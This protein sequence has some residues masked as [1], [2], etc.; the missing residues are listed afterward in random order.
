M[1]LKVSGGARIRATTDDFSHK[2][3]EKNTKYYFYFRGFRGRQYAIQEIKFLSRL[4]WPLFS[5]RQGWL[6]TLHL[7][8]PGV[9]Q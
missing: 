3:H 7:S 4:D 9:I 8:N 6:E 5:Q 1:K 2:T